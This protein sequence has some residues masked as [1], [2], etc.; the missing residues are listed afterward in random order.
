M[1]L[2]SF[3]LDHKRYLGKAKIPGTIDEWHTDNGTEFVNNNVGEFCQDIGTRRAMSPPYT[4]TR[5]ASAERIWGIVLR[6]VAKMIAHAGKDDKKLSLWP[7]AMAQAVRIH[8]ALP[9][10]GHSPPRAPAQLLNLEVTPDLSVFKVT[11]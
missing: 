9:T 2:K 4:A 11:C 6:P 8:N 3:L 5:N 7:Y 10:R 1:A